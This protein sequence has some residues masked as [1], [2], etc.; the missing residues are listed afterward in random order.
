[1]K[2]NSDK[3]GWIMA[4]CVTRLMV[5]LAVVVA[6]VM[7]HGSAAAT[8]DCKDGRTRVGD[9]GIAGM[10]FKGSMTYNTE[11]GEH[12]WYF[13][14]EPKVLK[15]DPK[16]PS[17]GKLKRGDVIMAI[18]GM[19]ITTHKAGQR[20]GSIAPGDPVTLAVR[21][22]NRV[23]DV[24]ITARAVCPEDHPMH[25][26]SFGMTVAELNLER[27]SEALESLSR[28]SELDIEI[29]ELPELGELQLPELPE[30]P[31]FDLRPRA[32]FGMS[33]TC[34]GC[35][36]TQTKKDETLKWSFDKPPKVRS[37]E[38]GGPADDAGLEAGDVLTHVD[39]I[40]I[41]SE[42]G[43]EKFSS[44]EPGD[45]VS[46]TI[47]RDGKRQIVRAVA[48][49]RP[50]AE[51]GESPLRVIYE[52]RKVVVRPLRFTGFV[53]GAEVEVRGDDAVKVIDD[54]ETGEIVIVTRGAE[55]RVRPSA[56]TPVEKKPA[57]QSPSKER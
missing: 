43:G 19:P 21:R 25:V 14:A 53:A 40:K 36:I 55:I 23:V 35:A 22:K 28:I 7:A 12:Q 49:E 51:V 26:E 6:I 30:V 11:T 44:M 50:E 16:G 8:E 10:N 48:M 27:L 34:D 38:P 5:L 18:D 2:E 39:G 37:V 52:P 42:K 1:L 24:V 32:W 9:L 20:F 57:G 15:V 54:E 47:R 3:G 33:L 17:A 4:R 31:T 41:D 46:W 56:K 29:P 13:Q 45:T